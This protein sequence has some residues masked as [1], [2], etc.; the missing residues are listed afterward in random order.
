MNGLKT[1]KNASSASHTSPT[2]APRLARVS[3]TAWRARLRATPGSSSTGANPVGADA[4]VEIV[5][6]TASIDIAHPRVGDRVAD[7]GDEET[8][9]LEDRRDQRQ[10][11]QQFPVLRQGRLD[12][13]PAHPRQA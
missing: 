5:A 13:E 12:R 11:H 4:T 6:S 9:E 3:T 1:A 2:R 7:V 10:G 8:D